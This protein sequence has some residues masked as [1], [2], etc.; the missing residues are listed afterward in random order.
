MARVSSCPVHSRFARS[1]AP[2]LSLRV[3]QVREGMSRMPASAGSMLLSTFVKHLVPDDAIEEQAKVEIAEIQAASRAV[4]GTGPA[5]MLTRRMSHMV[6]GDTIAMSFDNLAR[7][8]A[9][10]VCGGGAPRR[11]CF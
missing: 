1:L 3:S 4:S 11:L 2:A 6:L 9:L 10:T 5:E 8:G 7:Q